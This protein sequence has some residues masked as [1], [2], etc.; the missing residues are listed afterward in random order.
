MSPAP[1][2]SCTSTG[3]V[4]VRDPGVAVTVGARFS[5]SVGRGVDV[6]TVATAGLP[7]VPAASIE[8]TST[9]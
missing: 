9:R 7:L 1:L 3:A 4:K 5:V 8:R 6:T 2:A